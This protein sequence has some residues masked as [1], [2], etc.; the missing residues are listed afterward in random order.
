[1]TNELEELNAEDRHVAEALGAMPRAAAP[2]DFNHKVR[3]RIAA[4]KQ[5]SG[6][7]WRIFVPAFA[8]VFLVA[9]GAVLYL[10]VL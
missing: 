9:L 7:G 3:G 1:M 5:P 2:T 8:A 10:G 4:R 6:S